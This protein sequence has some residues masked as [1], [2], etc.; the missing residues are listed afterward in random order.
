[1]VDPLA[2]RTPALGDLRIIHAN[3]IGAGN[4]NILQIDHGN[5]WSLYFSDPEGNGVVCY[6]DTP[7]HVAQLILGRITADSQ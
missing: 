4:E 3:L 7:F 6:V 1:M 2:F 5:A